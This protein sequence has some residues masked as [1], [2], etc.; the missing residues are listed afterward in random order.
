MT[1]RKPLPRIKRCLK[2]KLKMTIGIMGDYKT[3]LVCSPECDCEGPKRMS[4]RLAI[5]AWN[6]MV[7][8]EKKR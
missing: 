7:K 4:D 5:L 8:K 1:P 6:R 3:W 2:H